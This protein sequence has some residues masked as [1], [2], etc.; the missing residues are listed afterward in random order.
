MEKPQGT[1]SQ[2]SKLKRQSKLSDIF[3]G[4]FPIDNADYNVDLC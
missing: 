2:I 3:Q 1:F 4:T